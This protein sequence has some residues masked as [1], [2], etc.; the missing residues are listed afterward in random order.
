MEEEAA[1][2]VAGLPG[3]GDMRES[4]FLRHLCCCSWQARRLFPHAVCDSIRKFIGESEGKHSGEIRFAVEAR[5]PVAALCRH[6]T[7]RERA[8]E[9]FSVLRIWDTEA[10]NGVLIY[11]LLADRSVEIIADRGVNGL[12]GEA[13]WRDICS[14]MENAFRQ[15]QFE[16]GVKLGIRKVTDELIRYFPATE[17][18]RDELPDDPVVM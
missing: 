5:L 14:E 9:L 2:A 13:G 4:R 17:G 10:N 6:Q 3:D 16:A 12:V 7:S 18:D 8:L 15:G 11:L 1:L